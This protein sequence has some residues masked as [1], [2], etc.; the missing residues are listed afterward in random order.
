ML[1][2][3]N[4]TCFISRKKTLCEHT[5]STLLVLVFG[6]VFSPPNFRVYS[7]SWL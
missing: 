2:A 3:I 5:F 1:V 6:D 7:V 4:L